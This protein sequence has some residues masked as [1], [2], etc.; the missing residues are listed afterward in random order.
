VTVH[1]GQVKAS[2][3]GYF[4][5]VGIVS[6]YLG[7]YLDGLGLNASDI[8]MLLALPQVT[9]IFAPPMWGWLADTSKRPDLILKLSAA[10]MVLCA[11]AMAW[12]APSVW[13]IAVVLLLFYWFSAAQM[14]LVEAYAIQVSRGHAGAYGDMR[15][16]GSLGFILTVLLFGVFIDVAGRQSL[17][18]VL[19]ILCLGLWFICRRFTEPPESVLT[20]AAEPIAPQMRLAKVQW[21]LA[22][23]VLH[24]FAHSALYAFLSLY[25]A[26]QGYSA[27]AI[28]A[29]WATGVL[30]E[31]IWFKVQQRFFNRISSST[32]L[33]VCAGVGLIRFGTL[34]ALDGVALN[35]FSVGLLIVLQASHALTFAAHHTAAMNKMHEWFDDGQQSRAQSIFV[36]LVYG[37]GGAA[38]AVVAGHLWEGYS[39]PFAFFGAALASFA[40][41]IAAYV[42]KRCD[43]L[44]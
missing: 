41:L 22:S 26:R 38:G 12:A 24:V 6:P 44:R 17:P 33:M 18:W 40:A 14:P 3:A 21:V 36:A 29:L 39:P 10:A 35:V 32:M 4:A 13:L 11:L 43:S 16:W 2:L 15:V 34:G 23:C 1:A 25:L 9:R 8:A 28:G 20:L 31:I 19:A 30:T 7:L 42:A 27:T 5:V 37:V